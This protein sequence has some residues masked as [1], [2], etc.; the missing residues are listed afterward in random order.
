MLAEDVSDSLRADRQHSPRARSS[1]TRRW[2][3]DP[4]KTDLHSPN[5]L[6]RI[7]EETGLVFELDCLCRRTALR[8]ARGLQPGKRSS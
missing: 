1:A 7:A 8:G 3:A 6:F 4:G 5:A 2:C